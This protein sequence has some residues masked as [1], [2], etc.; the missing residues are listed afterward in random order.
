MDYKSLL[1]IEELQDKELDEAQEH[2][3]KCEI[4][5]RNALKAYRKAQRALAEANARC[6]YLYHNRNLFSANI[7]PHVMEDSNMFWSNMQHQHTEANLNCITNMS[8][9]DMP[10]HENECGEPNT[11]RSEPQEEEKTNDVGSS[12]HENN[13]NNVLVED[14]QTSAFG[15]KAGDS[16]LDSH[17]EGICSERNTEINNNSVNID[18][19]EDSLLLEATLRSQ[20]FARLGNRTY[21]KIE[22][23]QSMETATVEREDGEIME[24][25]GNI[26][27]FETEKDQIYDFGGMYY[28]YFL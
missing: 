28:L 7:R 19:N 25:S 6:S 24:D 2:R 23:G 13:S 27:S 15:L 8:E 11:S 18:T 22:S 4:E 14:E 21:K 12:L 26:L 5:E 1:E 9:N 16:S 20:L 17:G 10:H 3:R